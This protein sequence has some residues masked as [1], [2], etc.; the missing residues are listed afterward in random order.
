MQFPRLSTG[1]STVVIID[2]IGEVGALL[3][4]AEDET[5]ADGVSGAGRYK[6]RIA[7]A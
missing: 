1:V 2:A 3:N 4:F 5:A 6:H 7:R